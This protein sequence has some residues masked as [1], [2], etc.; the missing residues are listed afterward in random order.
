MKKILLLPCCLLGF[1]GMAFAQ[2]QA[3]RPAASASPDSVRII[4]ETMP[5]FPGGIKG[6][7]NFLSQ[8]L[9]YP[10]QARR[11]GVQG[12]VRVDFVVD[13]QGH[14]ANVLV[15]Q[16]IGYGCDE[17]AIRVV[18]LMPTWKPGTQDGKPVA[19][20]FSLPINFRRP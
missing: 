18:Q 7:S 11:A 19:V 13:E 16:G 17:E 14:P 9:K 15:S 8:H 4:V 3:A 20:Q 10:K 6:L 1:A 2:D 5:E 12:T